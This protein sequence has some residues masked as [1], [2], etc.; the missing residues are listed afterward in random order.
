MQ[1]CEG[2]AE[3]GPRSASGGRHRAAILTTALLLAAG[4]A[5]AASAGCTYSHERP[6]AVSTDTLSPTLG[7]MTF[8]EEGNLVILTVDVNATRFHDDSPFIPVAVALANKRVEPYIS[9][10]RESFYL[11][12]A[13]GRR[14]GLAGVGEVQRLQKGLAQDRKMTE[15]S[16]QSGKFNGFRFYSTTFFPYVSGAILRDRVDL[17]TFG[18]LMDV[19][20]FPRPEGELRGG[21]FELHLTSRELPQEVFVVFEVPLS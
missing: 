7:P 1:Q 19:L 11:M 5:A 4:L 12:D 17:P 21:V 10:S 9:I 13:F 20:Y 14:Y 15:V 3:A 6:L 16:F 18:A 8:K 2:E